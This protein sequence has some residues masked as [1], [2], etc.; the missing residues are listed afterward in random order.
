M[1]NGM[2]NIDLTKYAT[3]SCRFRWTL[4]IIAICGSRYAG[5]SSLFMTSLMLHV[6][7]RKMPNLLNTYIEYIEEA[8]FCRLTMQNSALERYPMRQG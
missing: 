6:P 5:D 1:L 2:I 4:V 7:T 8:G 3:T